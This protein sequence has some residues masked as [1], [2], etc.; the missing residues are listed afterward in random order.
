[1]EV[2][3]TT[4]CG[5]TGTIMPRAAAL[6]AAGGVGGES[7][8]A[9]GSACGHCSSRARLVALELLPSWRGGGMYGG[10]GGVGGRMGGHMSGHMGMSEHQL[11]MGA[12]REG[13]ARMGGYDE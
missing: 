10:M 4:S 12:R 7:G 8:G 5:C 2:R 9:C 1:M 13:R 11:A 3:A 6:R